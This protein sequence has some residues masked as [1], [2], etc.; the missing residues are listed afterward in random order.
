GIA[1]ELP[2]Y[3][4][5]GVCLL[6]V[7][8]LLIPAAGGAIVTMIF[9]ACIPAKRSRSFMVAA[10]ALGMAGTILVARLSGFGQMLRSRDF[11]DF[12]QT[13]KLLEAGSIE[14][15]PN[16]WMAEG[17]FAAARGDWLGLL[18]WLAVLASTGLFLLQ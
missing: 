8:F 12:R 13:L 17:T 14:L 16:T 2:L 10:L 3:F 11:G 4:Y 18:Y 1:K 6:I 15:F 5:A 7:P 9:A